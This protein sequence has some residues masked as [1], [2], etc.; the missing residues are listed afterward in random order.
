MSRERTV[1]LVEPLRK[2]Q[3][4]KFY[5]TLSALVVYLMMSRRDTE[6]GAGGLEYGIIVALAGIAVI[7]L[8][9]IFGNK[10]AEFGS[11]IAG[12]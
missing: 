8:M 4:M 6:R 2:V 7:A 3:V 10:V 12:L 5:A 11:K 1:L 9:A